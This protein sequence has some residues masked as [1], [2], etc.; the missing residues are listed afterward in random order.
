MGYRITMC[1]EIITIGSYTVTGYGLCL[2]LAIIAAYFTTELG[3]KYYKLDINVALPMVASAVI[4]GFIGAKALYL[5]Q[6]SDYLRDAPSII[7]DYITDGFVIYGGILVAIPS[8]YICLK[9]IKVDIL[10]YMDIGI[11]AIAIAQAIGRFGCFLA[12]CCY[13]M[14]VSADSLFAVT[15]PDVAF[16]PN[17]YS[18]FPIQLVCVVLNLLNFIFLITLNKQVNIKGITLSSYMITYGIGRFII[19]FFRGDEIRGSY[20]QLT[21]SQWISLFVTTIGIICIIVCIK[22]HNKKYKDIKSCKA[23]T[24]KKC[25][26]N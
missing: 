9:L 2:A 6:I 13:G 16:A 1:T 14:R 15:Y 4:P 25:R 18:Y 3:I 26:R 24:T 20:G 12:G 5:L 22:M 23:E 10:Q 7:T 17:G 8:V 11:S 21:T 19:E